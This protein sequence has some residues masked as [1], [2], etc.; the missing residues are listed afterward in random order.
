MRHLVRNSTA[1]KRKA[2]EELPTVAQAQWV[3]QSRSPQSVV[4]DQSIG[5]TWELDKMQV[6]RPQSR[7]P[8]S[9]TV[10]PWPCNLYFNRPK[11]TLM[12]AK[13]W[14]PLSYR[15][16]SFSH[17]LLYSKFRFSKPKPLHHPEKQIILK[18]KQLLKIVLT[19]CL[20]KAPFCFSAN[21]KKSSEL[22][23]IS[24]SYFSSK[25]N[26]LGHHFWKTRWLLTK[27]L[28]A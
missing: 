5:S 13:V 26:L 10:G 21:K 8:E 22:V 3:S 28:A 17:T 18:I 23:I 19:W 4:L 9:E 27:A 12:L 25:N 11:V 20:N 16:G 24:H 6:P 15:K 14:E 1:L 7:L 2:N